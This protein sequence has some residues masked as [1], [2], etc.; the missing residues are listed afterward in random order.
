MTSFELAAF[1]LCVSFFVLFILALIY[2]KQYQKAGPNQ[3]LIISGRASPYIDPAT[4][5]MQLRTFRIVR[6]GGTF[7]WPVVER[8]DHLSLE[9]M[10][11]EV[12]SSSIYPSQGAPVTI[13]GVAQ[14]KI[15]SDDASIVTAAEHFL[16][17]QSNEIKTVALQIIEAHL[18][19]VVKA[20][21]LEQIHRDRD[22]INRRVQ[23]VSSTDLKN[24]GLTIV[25]FMIK[26][27]HDER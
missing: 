14:V 17:K 3:A 5:K 2:A 22:E 7:V 26:N 16:S 19:S 23:D 13:D 20:M 24:M 6:S 25:S 10:A 11:I 4:G 1:A 27:I 21:T 18:R 12:V 8:V 15:G 9:V